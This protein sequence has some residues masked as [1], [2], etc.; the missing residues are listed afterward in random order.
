MS[1]DAATSAQTDTAETSLL[2]RH[3][4][5]ALLRSN[6]YDLDPERLQG[7]IDR[8]AVQAPVNDRWGGVHIEDLAGRL[9]TLRLWAIDS[10]THRVKLSPHLQRVYRAALAGEL[11]ALIGEF[12]RLADLRLC[13]ILLAAQARDREVGEQLLATAFATLIHRGIGF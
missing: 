1:R 9:D 4:V 6:E 8:G 7:L 5:I 11:P 3:E 12:G 13:L 10:E 2:A